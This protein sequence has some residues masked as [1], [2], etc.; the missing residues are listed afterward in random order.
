V[1]ERLAEPVD[2]DVIDSV[3]DSDDRMNGVRFGR[4]S[5]PAKVSFD[6]PSHHFY[7]IEIGGIRPRLT[8]HAA[9]R[10]LFDALHS[11]GAGHSVLHHMP[12]SNTIKVISLSK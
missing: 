3:P 8:Q 11:R 12:L 10:E 9:A 5:R 4:D 6:D 7:G 2:G 1:H